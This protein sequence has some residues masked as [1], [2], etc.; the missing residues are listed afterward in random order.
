M[1]VKRA[2]RK[3]A[4]KKGGKGSK[5][6]EPGRRGGDVRYE[7]RILQSL[8]RIMRS[9]DIYSRKLTLE[10]GITAPQL[11]CL[12]TVREMGPMTSTAISNEMHVSPSTLVGILDRL[13]AKGLVKR[14][15]A[16]DDRRRVYI[17]VTP[18]GVAVAESAPSPLQDRLVEGLAGL[19]D[20]EL[21]TISGSLEKI[22]ELMEVEGISAAPLLDASEASGKGNGH[23]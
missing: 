20:R 8:R 9:V 10:H 1:A 4:E 11:I 23:H 18:G 5:E 15:R 7:L 19:T 16:T 12:L 17:T 3:K 6:G 13:E 14:E 21:K 2:P 22:V